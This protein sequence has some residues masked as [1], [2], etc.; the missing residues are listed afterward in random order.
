MPMAQPLS[1]EWRAKVKPGPKGWRSDWPRATRP[2]RRAR[3]ARLLRT[4]RPAVA[5]TRTA[6]RPR[7]PTM[8]LF[9]A[10]FPPGI[11]SLGTG[12]IHGARGRNGQYLNS[13]NPRL[14]V[15]PG[16]VDPAPGPNGGVGW[17][18][19]REGEPAEDLVL[20]WLGGIAQNVI[21]LAGGPE[22]AALVR[23]DGEPPP[24]PEE[25]RSRG[26]PLGS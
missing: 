6:A 11:V 7:V 13:W 16:P 9:R 12:E 21:F 8:A 3:P 15:L 10:S 17:V 2:V 20:R 5:A 19:E 23:R 18:Q 24:S 25:P 4:R 22:A 1:M 26:G 14:P